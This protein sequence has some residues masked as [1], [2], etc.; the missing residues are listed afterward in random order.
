MKEMKKLFNLTA[1]LSAVLFVG[2]STIDDELSEMNV[3]EMG[4]VKTE[5]TI[6][7]PAKAARGTRMTEATVQGQATPVFRGI[8][9]IELYPFS[10]KVASITSSTS[11]PSVIH[12]KH[13]TLDAT[14][15]QFGPSDAE[16]DDKITG[17]SV[18]YSGNNAHLY[19][20]I[21]IAIGTKA[22]MFYGM[23]IP[24]TGG[25]Y[26]TDG[27][28]S[29]S[30]NPASLGD[31]TFSPTQIHGSTSTLGDNYV[32]IENYLTSIANTTG[33]SETN[34]VILQTLYT[35]FT[36]MK[37]GSWASLKGAVQQLYTTLYNRTF[38]ETAD[39]TLKTAIMGTITASGGLGTGNTVSESGGTLTFPEMGNFPADIS[40]PD[41]AIYMNWEW[42]DDTDHSLGKKF[43]MISSVTT[44]N[45]GL[46]I[47]EL[48]TYAYPAPLY[49]RVLSNIRTA[50]ESKASAYSSKSVWDDGTRGDDD[51]VLDAYGAE[52]GGTN[53]LVLRTTRSIAIVDQVQYAVARLD[54]TVKAASSTLNDGATPTASTI[55]LTRTVSS[56]TV[57]NFPVTAILIGGQ[58]PVD[59]EF[60]QKTGTSSEYTIYDKTI[61]SGVNLINSDPSTETTIHTLVFET[62][63][64]TT[65]NDAD[66][67]TKI[68]VEF[69]NNSGSL[70]VGHGG[71]IIYP[72]AK[73]YL[74]G[75]FDPYSNTTVMYTG[76][77]TPIKKTFV[78]DYTTTANIVINSLASAYNTL[79]DLRAPQLELGVS[80]NITWQ[81][82]I[83]QTITID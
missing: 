22:F 80:I 45:T 68:A 13:G 75:T 12:L 25:N 1:I 46:N 24:S 62:K 9:G 44:D 3:D 15:P 6:S 41:G 17:S 65:S 72:G 79:P 54:A 14:T 52:V 83:T 16:T 39:N 51:D 20:D 34:N 10:S 69:Q 27:T 64:A 73:F 61:P 21:E 60:K 53:D 4:V 8:Q 67:I 63:D 40:L 78:Q 82:G 2:C 50:N 7:F 59:Y 77:S 71:E 29:R 58:K 31:I 43:K 49:Y 32:D 55:A 5:F 57:Y 37:A 66:A 76:T 35:N 74:V 11:V 81:T 26:F 38:V 56:S 47:T 33:W 28:L 23:A 48:T 36:S 19:K 30:E 42:A 18:L 70:F